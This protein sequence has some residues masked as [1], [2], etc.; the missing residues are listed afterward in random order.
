MTTRQLCN[1]FR[2]ADGYFNDENVDMQKF[3]NHSTIKG[4]CRN[5]GCKNNEERINALAVY[6]HMEFKNL[7]KK[8]SEYNKYDECFLM[9]L[10]QI[11]R[12]KYIFNNYSNNAFLILYIF[13]IIQNWLCFYYKS[14]NA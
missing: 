5:G 14:R 7:I 9:W 11:M 6:I 2:E 3:N 8:K 4:Y 10:I 1:L 12:Y 13:I